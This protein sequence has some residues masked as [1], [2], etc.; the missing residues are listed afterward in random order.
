[1]SAVHFARIVAERFD[2]AACHYDRGA[3]VQEQVARALVQRA[4]AQ[5]SEPRSVLDIG[6]GTGFV[7]EAIARRWPQARITAID[8][9]PSML[10]QARRKTP[11]L[12]IV[13]GD[14][15]AMEFTPAFDLI[16][17]SMV[18]HWL[19]TPRD[20]L[21]RWLKG[22]KPQGR[23]FAALLV[24]GSFQE[25]RNLCLQENLPEG[26][27]PFPPANFAEGLPVKTEL[28]PLKVAFP[29]AQDFLQ[30]LKTIG[31]A[32]PRPDHRPVG[33]PAMRRL[34]RRAPAPFSVTYNVLYIDAPS[35]SPA[36]I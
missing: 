1:M 21:A 16:F 34:L 5:S 36:S 7:A 29:S 23:L 24:D 4:V 33:T 31:A 9:A 14:V 13:K 32:T 2:R 30:R 18:L 3:A 25:W 19:P 11:G 8:G 20:V 12:R 27:W 26:I 28:Q 6:C 15:A 22:L 10:A 35:P 17:S